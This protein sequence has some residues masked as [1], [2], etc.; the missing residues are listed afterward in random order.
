MKRT[1]GGTADI[2]EC[3][4][5]WCPFDNDINSTY[6]S[7]GG[8]LA[9]RVK[10]TADG[11]RSGLDLDGIRAGRCS[12]LDVDRRGESFAKEA[13]GS[14]EATTNTAS[15]RCNVNVGGGARLVRRGEG[16]I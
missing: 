12:Q 15:K 3:D 14:G 2:A 1:H 7:L 5:S 4:G 6:K 10:C 9:R 8:E 16:G 11:A 13:R